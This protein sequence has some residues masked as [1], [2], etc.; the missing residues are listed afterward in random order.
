VIVI[1]I[2]YA[3]HCGREGAVPAVPVFAPQ[4]EGRV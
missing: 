2:R 1:V 4:A 3:A